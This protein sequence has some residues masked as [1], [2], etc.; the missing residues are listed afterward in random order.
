MFARAQTKHIM[1]LGATSYAV[2]LEWRTRRRDIY[3]DRAVLTAS[4][5]SLS[6]TAKHNCAHL[7]HESIKHRKKPCFAVRSAVGGLSNDN[8]RSVTGI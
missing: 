4:D 8:Y 2:C 1:L 5:D 7:G 6:R 3:L